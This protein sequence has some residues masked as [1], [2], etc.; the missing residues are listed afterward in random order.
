MNVYFISNLPSIAES[1]FISAINTR[2]ISYVNGKMSVAQTQDSVIGGYLITRDDIKMDQM[3]VSR[4]HKNGRL[5]I[6]QLKFA[7]KHGFT[8]GKD[9][10]SLNFPNLSYKENTKFYNKELDKFIGYKDTDKQLDI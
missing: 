10:L 3:F 5:F 6:N 2:I 7:D 8:T 1:K 9:C 4:L